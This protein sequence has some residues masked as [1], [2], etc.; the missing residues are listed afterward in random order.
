MIS[1]PHRTVGGYQLERPLGY[2]GMAE[3]WLGRHQ[4]TNGVAAIKLLRA[5]IPLHMRERFAIEQRI[6]ARL[7]HPN[8]VPVFDFS[9]SYIAFAYIDGED[10]RQR[11]RSPIDVNRAIAIVCT[12]GTAVA[13][14]HEKQV[15]H[16]DI[17]PANIL[18]DYRGTPFLSDFGIARILTDGS[19]KQADVAAGTVGFMAPE[20]I[21]GAATAASDQYSL[22]RTLLAILLSDALSPV[23]E[24]S[25]GRLPDVLRNALAL[26]LKRALS[27]S[28]NDRFPDVTQF[29]DALRDADLK[30]A[31]PATRLARLRR[32][33]TPFVWV[34]R[35]RNIDRIGESITRASYL[36]SD[37]EDAGFFRA[38]AVREFKEETG[39]SDIGWDIYSH[40]SRVGPI[41]SPTAFARASEIIVL[42]H[43]LWTNR[44]IWKEM[45][46]GV[47][48]DNGTA[49]VLVPDLA[50]FGQSALSISGP[51]PACTPLGIS[52]A[53]RGWIGL[54]GL[55]ELPTTIVGH[56]YSATALLCVKDEELGNAVHR[57]CISPVL[58]FGDTRLKVQALMF[59][60]LAFFSS[61]LPNPVRRALG[62]FMFRRDRVLAKIRIEA[63]MAMADA[64]FEAGGRRVAQLFWSLARARPAPASDLAL[65]TVVTTPDDPLVPSAQAARSIAACGLSDEQHFKLIY[66]GHFPQFMDDERPEWGARNIH[67]LVNL[68]DSITNMPRDIVGRRPSNDS[69]G[70]AASTEPPTMEAGS[71]SRA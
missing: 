69:N 26:P 55:Q 20:Q 23:S 21:Q 46:I 11:S 48:R 57:I 38:E 27:A 44:E 12:I 9:D 37:L 52:R 66:G 32:E 29:V 65:C 68:I 45:A 64:A 60:L 34:C 4:I 61:W 41:N 56:S 8:I 58:M 24:I 16:C 28:P 33:E 2:G 7:S 67:E 63:R 15:V 51:T 62:Q 18:L 6:V 13:S 53:V 47:A 71:Q 5:G 39:Y 42:L 10:L 54:L 35:P 49:I 17:K 50:G 43:G 3:V 40:G 30:T 19:E 36:L 1:T 31:E 59:G 25:I 70:Q 22:A 14:A